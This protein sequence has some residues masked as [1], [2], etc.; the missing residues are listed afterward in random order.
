LPL[1]QLNRATVATLD[2]L[3]PVV[4]YCHDGL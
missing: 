4:T 2:R 1:K 3:R